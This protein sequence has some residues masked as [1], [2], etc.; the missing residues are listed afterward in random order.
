[1]EHS[2]NYRTYRRAGFVHIPAQ[3]AP[4]ELHFGARSMTLE[5]DAVLFDRTKW[6][7]SYCDADT[8]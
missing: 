4:I 1:M 6:Y 5:D 2:P 8:V 3:L 7:I